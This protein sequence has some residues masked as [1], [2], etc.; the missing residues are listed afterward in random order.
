MV[1]FLNTTFAGF[2]GG[3]FRAMHSLAE[4][5]GVFFTPFFKVITLL[6]EKGIIFILLA[7]SL[8]LFKKTR[9]L[10][11]CMFGAVACGA[12]LTNVLLK[13]IIARPRPFETNLEFRGF[14]EF[15][16]KPL[17]DGYSF[18]S[19]HTTA[20]ASAMVALFIFCNKKWSWVA[21]IGV[22]LM[23]LSRI[24]L[25]AHYP[26]DVI[27]GIVVGA[28]SGVIAY[29]ITQYIFFLLEK[30][31]DKKFCSFCLDFD[32]AKYFKKEK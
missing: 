29:F 12:L 16:G 32:I 4:S 18:P 17:E 20:I 25:I 8:M 15:L 5:S 1:D 10:G 11:V 14:W 13:E 3:I 22:L 21:F 2:D 9:K 23:G 7:I 30:Y 26:T 6:G 31:K 24:Y 27:A 19:G 28:V